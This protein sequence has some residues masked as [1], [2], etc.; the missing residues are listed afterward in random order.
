ME[1]TKEYLSPMGFLDGYLSDYV[2]EECD[3]TPFYE[4][5]KRIRDIQDKG[6]IPSDELYESVGLARNNKDLATVEFGYYI[7]DIHY[8]LFDECSPY[9]IGDEANKDSLNK[10]ILFFL[11]NADHEAL[12][13]FGWFLLNLPGEYL[14]FLKR[15]YKKKETIEAKTIWD[16][17]IVLHEY[18]NQ[19]GDDTE[20]EIAIIL[21]DMFNEY[22]ERIL[23]HTCP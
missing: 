5:L 3:Q 20:K 11:L 4:A 17:P 23:T 14:S 8:Y 7:S 6:D 12:F 22:R 19:Y 13:S 18:V 10:R 21:I 15:H 1:I 2:K 9:F 16:N